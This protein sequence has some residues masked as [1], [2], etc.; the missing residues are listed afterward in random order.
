MGTALGTIELA[1]DEAPVPGEDGV[2][3]GHAGHFLQSFA[4]ESLADLSKRASLGIR[5]AQAC[6]EMLTENSVLRRQI[7]VLEEQL[8]VQQPRYIRQ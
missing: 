2:R 3:F 5:Q 7:L 1:G 4:P 8:L 6:W